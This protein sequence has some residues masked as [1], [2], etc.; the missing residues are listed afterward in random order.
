MPG[1]EARDLACQG[2][3]MS[4]GWAQGPRVLNTLYV[5]SPL[6][7]PGTQPCMLTVREEDRGD[8][9]PQ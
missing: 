5:P 6:L 9:R 2:R 1:D 8:E 4:R 7:E 3:A